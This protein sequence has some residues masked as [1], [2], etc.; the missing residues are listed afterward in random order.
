MATGDIKW[1]AQGL[2]D[3]GNKLHNLSSDALRLGLI[4]SATTPTVGTLAPHFGGTGTTNMAT[5][6]VIAGTSYTAG[7]PTLTGVF[8]TNVGNTVPTLRAAQVTINQD[9]A[10]FT[11]A[12]WG[13]IYNN[14]NAAK[15]AIGF[16]DLGADR[17]IVS[18][19]LTLDWSGAT[20]DVLTITQS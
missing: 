13:I 14:T 12:R 2:H 5:N 16:I 1:F 18:G 10:G 20:D 9:A 4:T 15:Q 19:S 6:Q 8:W 11:N 17:S 7:G 3:L